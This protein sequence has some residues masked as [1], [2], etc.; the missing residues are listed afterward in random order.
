MTLFREWA[1]LVESGSVRGWAFLRIVSK[2]GPCQ[3]AEGDYDHARV[4]MRDPVL[5]SGAGEPVW[6]RPAVAFLAC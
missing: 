5:G 2:E 6:V 1:D 4:L 3:A